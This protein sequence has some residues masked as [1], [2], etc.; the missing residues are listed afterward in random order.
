MTSYH[1]HANAAEAGQASHHPARTRGKEST[2][3]HT[4]QPPCHGLFTL[5]RPG[6]KETSSRSPTLKCVLRVF[7]VVFLGA[8][9]GPYRKQSD[10]P[11][12]KSRKRQTEL[13]L[14][15]SEIW[16]S[17][18]SELCSA[19]S[20]SWHAR[21]DHFL[22][23]SCEGLHAQIEVHVDHASG[24][25]VVAKRFSRSYLLDGPRAFRESDA[26]CGEDPWTEMFLAMKLGQAGPD[27]IKGVLPCY[28]VYRDASDSAILMLEWASAG[29]VFEFAS[30]LGEP[31]P[32]REAQA[33][34]VLCALLQT[35]SRLHRLGVAHGDVSAENA[36]IR[37]E[38]GE[39]EVALLDFAMAIHSA[40]L[41]AVTGARGKPMYRA[42]ET[43]PENVAYDAR[44]A[45]LFACGVVGYALAIGNYPWQSTA[46]GCK[47][48]SYVQKNGL[49]RFFEKQLVSNW[50]RGALVF[51]VSE[52]SDLCEETPND[53]VEAALEGEPQRPS[54]AGKAGKVST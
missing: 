39:V 6:K 41:S 43:L 4:P 42:P 20:L 7:Y 29:D 34:H 45:D 32:E 22:R 13:A 5:A 52:R 15:Q 47:A 30:G 19:S 46:G 28:G 14:F 2:D 23:P 18:G 8:V 40:D 3:T 31:G 12:K 44:A 17:S 37:M 1:S 26:F 49:A 51:I 53:M 33:A 11:G 50:V 10:A 21:F 35:V 9:V 48:F 36:I 54:E 38:D 25:K 24:K 27:R 16:K